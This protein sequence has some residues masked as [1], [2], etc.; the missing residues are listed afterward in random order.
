MKLHLLFAAGAASLGCLIGAD[1]SAHHSFAAEF[2]R[3][4]PIDITGTVAKVEWMNPHARFYVDSIDAGGNKM[5][6]NF[7]LTSPNVLMR[8]GWTRQSLKV[9]DKVSVK[10]FRAKRAENVAN[11]SSVVLADGRKLF[12]GQATNFGGNGGADDGGDAAA[13]GSA[14]PDGAAGGSS[15][16]GPN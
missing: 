6:W 5:T 10:G 11:A 3:N 2:D 1:A 9:G 12:A 4:L 13:G 7:E 16:A 15:G 8:Q 14:P